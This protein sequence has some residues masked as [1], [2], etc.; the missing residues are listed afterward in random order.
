M[1]TETQTFI[2]ATDVKGIRIECLTC[3]TKTIVSL[4]TEQS[5]EHAKHLLNRFQ[6]QHCNAEWFTVKDSSYLE[7]VA[8]LIDALSA[9]RDRED[10]KMTM[11]LEIAAITPSVSRT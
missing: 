1:T 11:L 5:R 9:I 6:C 10:L 7:L 3:H 8:R 2:A 4:D